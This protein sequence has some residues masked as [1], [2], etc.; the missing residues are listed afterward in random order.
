MQA[1]KTIPALSPDTP[2]RFLH[3][4]GE[5]RAAILQRSRI[6]TVRDLLFLLPTRYQDRRSTSSIRELRSLAHPVTLRGRISAT[7]SR[8]SPVRQ[9]K[10][11]E[12]V[13]ED[14]SGAIP[15]VWFNQPF[16]SEKIHRGMYLAIYGQPR[17]DR[18][19]RVQI[20]SPEWET[21]EPDGEFEGEGQIVPVYPSIQNIPSKTIRSLTR[22][23]LN[24]A[25]A[26]HDPLP[27]ELRERLGVPDLIS[28]ILEL[29]YPQEL[30]PELLESRSPAHLRLAAEEFLAFQLTLQ[31][32]RREEERR[33]KPHSVTIDDAVRNKVRR[34]LPFQLTAAQKRV[35]R[36][37]ASDLQSERPMYRLLQGDVGSGKTIVALLSALLV[38]E[39]GHQAAILAPTELL[40]EQH[41]RRVEQLLQGLGVTIAR[42][43]GTMGQASRSETLDRL[44]AGRIDLIVGTHALLEPAVRFRSLA[45]AIVDEQH[46]FGVIQR[47]K[48][49]DKGDLPDVLVMTA[50]PIPRSLAISVYGDLDLSVI[51]TLPPGRKPIQTAVR[52]AAQLPRIYRFIDQELAAGG[53]AYI[54]YPIIEES[55]KIDLYSLER[56]HEELL[57]VFPGR[58]IETLHGRRSPAD[59]DRVMRQFNRGEIDILA[60]T[61]VI[62]VGIDVPRASVMVIMEADRFGLAQLHQLRGRVGRGTR[63]SF[64]ILVRDET[65]SEESK[66]R[67]RLFAQAKDGFEVAE[68]D[69][70]LRGA[71]DFF[72][73]RQAGSPHF[74]FG[75]LLRDFALMQRARLAAAELAS[76]PARAEALLKELSHS[77]RPTLKRD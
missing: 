60:S 53:Q 39:S 14:G 36:E 74:R 21:V 34:L 9:M 2:V 37:I 24:A 45:L 52:G 70:Q 43:T 69:L 40:A 68:R 27:V 23:A 64:C 44:S 71:G 51:D 58:R 16:L 35:C 32:R 47:Q 8:T 13:L 72:G 33:A 56:G 55:E 65:A 1:L 11:F 63:K 6:E 5:G 62:E 3:G 18:K 38:I 59:R 67:L 25:P 29:H 41:F 66:Q 17:V 26:L 49:F 61:T 77:P 42:L 20:E 10:I 4:V 15:L 50:T 57:E 48:L 73:T 31:L 76:Q 30:T 12:A 54:V 7:S 19:G 22:Q 75:D 46:R 28:A